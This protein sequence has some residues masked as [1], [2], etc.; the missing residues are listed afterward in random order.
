MREAMFLLYRLIPFEWNEVEILKRFGEV[1]VDEKTT[2][3]HYLAIIV[4]DTDGILVKDP[5]RF[6]HDI[7]HKIRMHLTDETF[8]MGM[9]GP[10]NIEGLQ[11]SFLQV[12][13]AKNLFTIPEEAW[14]A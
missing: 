5:K 7:C 14:A 1:I 3:N 11:P 2:H 13:Q 8:E 9:L 10:E 6:G 12:I 4:T